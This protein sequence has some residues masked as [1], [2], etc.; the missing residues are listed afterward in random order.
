MVTTLQL[1]SE[2][3]TCFT[4]RIDVTLVIRVQPITL[5]AWTEVG[6]LNDIGLAFKL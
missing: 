3:E 5:E 6:S 2:N 1:W 4:K